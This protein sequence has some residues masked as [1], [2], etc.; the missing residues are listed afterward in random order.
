MAK[1]ILQIS[2]F[3]F[4]AWEFISAIYESSWDKLI[5]SRNNNSFKQCVYSQF[6]RTP[7]NIAIFKPMKEKQADMSRIPLS[8]PS[9]LSKTVLAKSKYFNK[10]LL[11]NFSFKNSDYL[12][13]QVSKSNI[14]NIIRIKDAFSNLSSNKINKIHKV[15]NNSTQKDKLKINITTKG[16]SRKQIIVSIGTNNSERIIAQA[17]NY[18]SNISRLL[19][20]IKYKVS[21]NYIWFDNKR[22][23]ITTNKV[24]IS[25]DFKIMKNYIK[26]LNNVDLNNVMNPILSQS[27]SYLKILDIS[28]F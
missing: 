19:K 9:R 27:K 3:G 2:E 11:S 6:N 28:Y 16:P 18:I 17:D 10:N 12:Y 22:V 25:S 23:F 20:S 5:V 13:A 21:M 14:E 1:D 7:N 15:M 26:N 8:I 4:T 24:A